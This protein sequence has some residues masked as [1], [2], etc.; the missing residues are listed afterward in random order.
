MT[1]SRLFLATLPLTLFALLFGVSAFLSTSAAYDPAL[2]GGAAAAIYVSVAAYLAVAYIAQPTLA[3]NVVA[4]LLVVVGAVFAFV[5]IGQF[6]Y[7][8]YPETPNFIRRLGNATSIMPNLRL[9]YL[10][11]NAAATFLESILPLAVAVAISR[12][13]RLP[14]RLTA[15]FAAFV[16]LYAV[17]LTYS[18]GSW[19]AL[20][21]VAGIAFAL[22]VFAR[23][24]AW[25]GIAAVVLLIVVPIV[26]V[27]G[28]AVIGVDRLPGFARFFVE[29]AQSRLELYRN[30][31]F[32]VRDYAF[33]GIGPG[34]TFGMVY[35]RYSL[36]IQVPFLTYSHNL[37][38]AVWLSQG[39]LGLIALI[40][41]IIGFFSYVIFVL[42]RGKPRAVFHGAYLGVIA[43]LVHGMTD[44]RQY[45]ESPWIMPLLFIGIGLTVATGGAAIRRAEAENKVLRSASLPLV[46]AGA[47]LVVAMGAFLLFRPMLQ[48]AWDTN[49]AALD[50]TRAELG[51]QGSE[52]ERDALYTAATENYSFALTT[53]GDYAPANRR[54]GNLNANLSRYEAAVPLLEKA[55][56]AEPSNPA[57]IKGL[58]LA[59][60]WVGRTEDAARMLLMLPDP[61]AIE[62]E[63]Y[64]W[65]YYRSG[66][67]RNEPLL[68]GYAWETAQNLV[69][70][71]TNVDLWLQVGDYYRQAGADDRA[72]AAYERVLSVAPEEQRALDGLAA[73][74]ST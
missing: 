44:A 14:L 4:G 74:G 56:A 45:T 60:V 10:H 40:G 11:P 16:M 22:W 17:F 20:A 42:R 24:P 70:D 73:L 38:L 19:V 41:I 13:I 33:T 49:R 52:A 2:V 9:G 1:D 64:T 57:A 39:L 5:F 7:Q 51:P 46:Y 25:V 54:L 58:G 31:L 47:V 37:P 28:I 21:V 50:E 62:N 30:T 18:R 55:Y 26:A 66:P 8:N 61:V 36:L 6:E 12:R 59:Y 23:L 15:G 69:P 53:D 32:L 43:A 29:T 72:R 27:I 63:L 68:A 3:G 67:E 71:S 48:A 34:E 35:A 65:G